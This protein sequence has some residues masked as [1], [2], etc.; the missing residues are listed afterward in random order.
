MH[1]WEKKSR[2]T[3]YVQ[4]Y[5]PHQVLDNKTLEEDFSRVKLEVRHL[6][7]FHFPVYIHVPKEKMTK[8][9]PSGKKGIFV[10]YID[11][12]K[13]YHIYFPGFKNI[14]ITKDVTFDEEGYI[15]RI[16]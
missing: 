12:S 11:K 5:T 2:T 3:V 16:Q 6:R 7:I 1:L 9:D 4:K 15:H 13:S 14:D 8:L 10:G